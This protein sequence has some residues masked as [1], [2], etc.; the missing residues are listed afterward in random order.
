MNPFFTILLLLS[1]S[2]ANA[3]PFNPLLAARL[4]DSLNYYV[5]AVGNI[6]GMSVGVYVPGGGY[7]TGVAGISHAGQA[8][9]PG[10]EM[11]IAS[12][13]KLF[14]A[15][16]M[17]KLEQG[18]VLDLDDTIHKWLPLYA[19]IN[20]AITIRQLLNHSSGISDPIFVSPYM[21]SIMNNPT[22]IFTPA[23][24]L[25]WVG[26][27]VFSPGAGYYYSNINY[28]LAGM[29]AESATGFH[30]S[31][32]IRDSLLTPLNLDSTF[33][34][35]KEPITVPIAHRWYYGVDYHDTPRVALNTA[36][37]CA[38]AMFSTAAEMAQWYHRLMNNE[39]LNPSSMAAMTTF[40]TAGNYG[41]GLQRATLLGKTTWGHGGATWGYRSKCIYDPCMKVVVCGLT[42]CFPSGMEGVTAIL[43][44]VLFSSLPACPGSIAGPSSVCQGQ[45]A[46]TYTIAP[47]A[48]ATS[49]QWT[50][51]AGF[52]GSSTS[53][54]IT[55]NVGTTAQSGAITVKGINAYGEG[56][57]AIFNVN[58]TNCTS[59]LS[60]KMFI[61]GYYTGNQQM[62]AV[63]MNQGIG[64]N[65]SVC[66]SV[67]V[68]LHAASAPYTLVRSVKTVLSTNGWAYCPFSYIPGQNMLGN[69]YYIV[70]KHRNLLESWSANPVLFSGYTTTYDMSDA[71]SKV[72]GANCL[73]VGPAVYALYN[74]DLIADGNIDLL[75]HP[76]LEQAISAF[77]YGYQPTDLNG[78]GNVDLLDMTT[79]EENIN[80]FI[81]TQ[82]P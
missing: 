24:V 45:T 58:V 11:G 65:A 56:V 39:V 73:Q 2:T 35:V 28:I 20:P 32:L 48:N 1:I 80:Q 40:T 37:G 8:I 69:S 22:R 29:I 15:A 61:Q 72:Y 17:L 27:P 59:Y 5:A 9:T 41:L 13:T 52:S 10:M 62:G 12:N 19:N 68:E 81:F 14:V 23:E 50:L 38:G 47:V 67:T 21:D 43:Y 44:R 25:A 18:N 36:G 66:D 54:S 51:P 64:S 78:D 79:L 76:E 74:G 34:D 46:L 42:N 57:P 70:V 71:P 75:D 55:V 77:Q 30:I 53:N 31:K 33:Y 6:K 4:Q 49:Y 16:V 7:W 60:L 26:P 82:H 3:Q 63:L